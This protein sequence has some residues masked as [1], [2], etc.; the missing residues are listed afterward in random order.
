MEPAQSH[1]HAALA[2]AEIPKISKI[3]TAFVRH[4]DKPTSHTYRYATLDDI[5]AKIRKPLSD[6]GL[7]ITHDLQDLHTICRTILTHAPS[8]ESIETVYPTLIG[9]GDS[10]QTLGAKMTYARRYGLCLL[11]GLAPDEDLDGNDIEDK[12]HYKD[13][14]A[15]PNKKDIA[16]LENCKTLQDLADVW[17]KGFSVQQR[18]TLADVKNRVKESLLDKQE[19]L[20]DKQWDEGTMP[21]GPEPN[22][23]KNN[24]PAHA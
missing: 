5:M 1:I 10:H 12:D 8:G 23:V 4:K 2:A 14:I 22:E 11:L 7:V 3:K 18:R 24:A 17:E 15:A 19:S 6:Q 21:T 13:K 20:L 16:K 9:S